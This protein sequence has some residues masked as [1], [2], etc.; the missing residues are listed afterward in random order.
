MTDKARPGADQ[1]VA[2]DD[3]VDL[4]GRHADLLRS[5]RPHGRR[6]RR[7]ALLMFSPGGF[8]AELLNP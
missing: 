7:P 2:G 6:G 8:G 3:P 4:N 5:G 1:V